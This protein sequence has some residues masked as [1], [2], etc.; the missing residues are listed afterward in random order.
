MNSTQLETVVG[1]ALVGAGLLV[2]ALA[3][4]AVLA[5]AVTHAPF[6]DPTEE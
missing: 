5:Y 1:T 2:A 6:D 4:L 3:G